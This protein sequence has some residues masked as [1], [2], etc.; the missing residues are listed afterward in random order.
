MKILILRKGDSEINV[1]VADKDVEAFNEGG[2]DE[3]RDMTNS[4]L[5]FK[6]FY[7]GKGNT[8]AKWYFD[9]DLSNARET[10]IFANGEP[11]PYGQRYNDTDYYGFAC[12]VQYFSNGS[13]KVVGRGWF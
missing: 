4:G 9:T 11:T 13:Q 12:Q 10:R 1:V 7:S 3:I 8:T 6:D 2:Y 5:S